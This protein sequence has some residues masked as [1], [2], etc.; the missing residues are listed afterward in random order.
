MALTS[1]DETDLL[2]PLYRGVMEAPRFGQFLERLRRRTGAAHISLIMRQTNAL[3]RDA[4]ISIA[5][6]ELRIRP[7]SAAHWESAGSLLFPSTAMRPYRVYTL[8]EMIETDP[9]D[10]PWYSNA[11]SVQGIADLRLVRIPIDAGVSGVLT[12]ART[13]PCSAADSA[14]LSNLAPHVEIALKTLQAMEQGRLEAMLSAGGLSRSGTGWIVFDADARILAIEAQTRRWLTQ[15]TGIEP[16]AGEHLRAIGP[17]AERRLA[18]TAARFARDALA[19]P[20]SVMLG[21][22]PNS[23]A[24]LIPA[25]AELREAG[26]TGPFPE[27][28]MIAYC[29]FET[30]GTGER[31][32]HFARLFNLPPREAELAIALADGLSIAEAAAAMGLTLETA[33]NYTKRLYAQLGVRGQTELVGLIHRSSTVLV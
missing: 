4:D 32:A 29:R 14:L 15:Q 20:D 30:G 25:P 33:R 2:L 9:A 28:V 17:A 13:G 3:L 12:L 16:R 6:M 24:V 19:S 7:E 18:D 27:A 23:D 21:F 1:N 8:V 10:S 22:E 26:S 11:L 5:G 31:S